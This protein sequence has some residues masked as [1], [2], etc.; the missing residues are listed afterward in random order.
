MRPC[1]SA[2]DDSTVQTSR[3]HHNLCGTRPRSA[4]QV[5][6]RLGGGAGPLSFVHALKQ[7]TIFTSGVPA[8]GASCNRDVLSD[9]AHRGVKI[10]EVKGSLRRTENSDRMPWARR[11]RPSASCWSPASPNAAWLPVQM[12]QALGL[13]PVLSRRCALDQSHP[14][15]ASVQMTSGS[16]HFNRNSPYSFSKASGEPVS[17]QRLQLCQKNPI[18]RFS[19]FD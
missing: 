16:A 4:L 3:I 12:M 11:Y 19:C 7:Q 13:S 14:P 6:G 10:I 5:R 9:P 8:R 15:A 18:A 17:P 1:R 2:D